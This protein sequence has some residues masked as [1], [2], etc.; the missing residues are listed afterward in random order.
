[1]RYAFSCTSHADRMREEKP[2][3]STTTCKAYKFFRPE[4]QPIPTLCTGINMTFSTLETGTAHPSHLVKLRHRYSPLCPSYRL[5]KCFS[6]GDGRK[7]CQRWVIGPSVKWRSPTLNNIGFH[8]CWHAL[9][10]ALS[11]ELLCE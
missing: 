3:A 11:K 2:L 10:V 9:L 4:W 1:M 5:K 8:P 7:K 6:S